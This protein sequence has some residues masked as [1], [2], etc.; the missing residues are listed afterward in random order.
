MIYNQLP[1]RERE[2]ELLH[3]GLKNNQQAANHLMDAIDAFDNNNLTE[4]VGYLGLAMQA[5][6]RNLKIGNAHVKIMF[7]RGEGNLI[8]VGDHYE[9][10]TLP[11]TDGGEMED[12]SREWDVYV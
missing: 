5:L 1:N 3:E 12:G 2:I 11:S 10:M 4:K 9:L 6:K 7:E 8:W